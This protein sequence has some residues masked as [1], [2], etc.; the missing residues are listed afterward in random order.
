MS[1]FLPPSKILDAEVGLSIIGDGCLIKAGSKI[2]NSVIGIRSLIGTGCTIEDSMIMGSDYF[3]TL[4]ECQFV[5]GCLPMGVG[6]GTTIRRAIVDKNARIGEGCKIINKDGVKEAN[7]ESDGW[8]IKD[9]IIVVIKDALIPSGGSAP[10]GWGSI[11]QAG[12][13]YLV[14]TLGLD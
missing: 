1:R 9:G 11:H 10:E 13:V 3:E 5:P 2:K 4:D 6:D 14:T 8:V 12:T 7:R